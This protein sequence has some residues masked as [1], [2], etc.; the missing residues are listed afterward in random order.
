MDLCCKV[1][2]AKETYYLLNYMT[3]SVKD[4]DASREYNSARISNIDSF[5]FPLL[6]I[7]ILYM[8]FRIIAYEFFGTTIS[9]LVFSVQVFC[10]ALFW[11]AVRFRFKNLS[12]YIVFLFI[13][14]QG[15]MTI[16]TVSRFVPEFM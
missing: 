4:K 6:I 2:Y 15:L 1:L 10:M 14:N 8:I 9:S 11:G 3:L 12:P 16:L 13:F 5:Y 7:S